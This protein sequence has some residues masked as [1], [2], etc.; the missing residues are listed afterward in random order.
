MSKSR[1]LTGSLGAALLAT[2]LLIGTA[3]PANAGVG[4]CSSLSADGQYI[5][6]SCTANYPSPTATITVAYSCAGLK[7]GTVIRQ[8][9]T[10][11]YGSSFR[12]KSSCW[13]WVTNLSRVG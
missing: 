8:K 2:T 10:V 3:V 6:G 13:T 11:G 1:T 9:I 5:V 7:A 4:G 12:A